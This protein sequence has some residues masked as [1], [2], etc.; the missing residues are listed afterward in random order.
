ALTLDGQ[1]ALPVAH[2]TRHKSAPRRGMPRITSEDSRAEV[3]RL[4]H[5]SDA[6]LTGVGTVR[7]DDPL[8]TD[9]SGLPRRRPLLRVVLDSWVGL[10]RHSRIARSAERDLL[11]FV[12]PPAQPHRMRAL[13][14]LGAE[15]VEVPM[16]AGQVDLRRVLEEL[17][18]R[19]IRSVLL[20]AGPTL[21]G[22]ALKNGIVDKL[23][24]FYAP[25]VS[26]ESRVPF[27]IA[28]KLQL[29]PI[30][31]SSVRACGRDFVWEGYLTDVYGHHRT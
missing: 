20:E 18:K 25:R 15:M 13:Q 21:N 29:P 26:G 2:A 17:A 19:D 3:Q 8:L 1:L 9:R 27:A 31:S 10:P 24:L 5:A 4:R 28:P 30:R 23:V 11:I 7:A 16:R 12:G 22:S 6:I 14:K